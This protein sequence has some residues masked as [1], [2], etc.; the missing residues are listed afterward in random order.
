[1]ISPVTKFQQYW[2]LA[3]EQGDISAK[4]CTLATVDESGQSRLRTLV[5][6]DVTVDSFIVFINSS[7]PKWIDVNSSGSLELLCFWPSLMR[8]HRIR[9]SLSVLSQSEMKL[10]WVRKP[11]ESKLLDYFYYEH[12]QSSEIPSREE[13]VEGINLLK[14]RFPNAES[15]PYCENAQGIAIKADYVECWHLSEH[16]N[17]HHRSLY[18]LSEAGWQR[19]LLVP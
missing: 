2:R 6:R 10:H 12:P 17:I 18:T 19:Q 13:L 3:K 14:Q 4:Y 9:G 8:Q 7:S 5:L 1:M 11:Y 15:I 16:D